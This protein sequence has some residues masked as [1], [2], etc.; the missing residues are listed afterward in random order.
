VNALATLAD[1]A[2]KIPRD[3]TVVFTT[4]RGKVSQG[5]VQSANGAAMIVVYPGSNPTNDPVDITVTATVQ[6]TTVTASAKL[7]C[8][9]PPV[10]L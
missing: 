4:S 10:I 6:G 2:G 3:V 5:A 1:A 7:T 9:T 8:K